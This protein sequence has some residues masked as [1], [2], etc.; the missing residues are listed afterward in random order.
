MLLRPGSVVNVADSESLDHEFESSR[1]K[2]KT[3][4]SFEGC[5]SFNQQKHCGDFPHLS[6]LSLIQIGTQ[7]TWAVFHVSNVSPNVAEL[8][9]STQNLIIMVPFCLGSS[10]SF[11]ID[12]FCEFPKRYNKLGQ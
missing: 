12:W 11:Y 10:I 8:E 1:V 6:K 3:S 2:G 4:S 5:V 7:T 9:W